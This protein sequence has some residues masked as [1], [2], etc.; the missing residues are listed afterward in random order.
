VGHVEPP[1]ARPVLRDGVRNV[2]VQ[3]LVVAV[4]DAALDYRVRPKNRD[5]ENLIE[6]LNRQRKDILRRPT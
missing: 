4:G 2:S 6:R 3:L 1:A 5:A